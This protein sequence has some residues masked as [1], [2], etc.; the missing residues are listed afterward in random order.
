MTDERVNR[1]GPADINGPE[2][3]PTAIPRE[4]DGYR[5]SH[6]EAA[7]QEPRSIGESGFTLTKNDLRRV[8]TRKGIIELLENR[9]VDIQEVLKTLLYEQELRKLQVELVKLQRWVQSSGERIAILVEGRDTRRGT[10][11]TDGR[12]TGPMVLP[13]PYPPLAEQ[14]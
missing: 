11:E 12:R 2:T 13:V 7:E 8:N 1:A 10:T 5:P 14:R 6:Q 4:G 3:I 9:S